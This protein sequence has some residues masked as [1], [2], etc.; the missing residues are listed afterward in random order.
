MT[1]LRNQ[2]LGRLEERDSNLFARK[3][4]SLGKIHKSA[5]LSGP[6]RKLE[7]YN[8]NGKGKKDKFYFSSLLENIK[9]S[10][11]VNTRKNK[12]YLI[13]ATFAGQG[14]PSEG[15]KPRSSRIVEEALIPKLSARMKLSGM[16]AFGIINE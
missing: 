5:F 6:S 13:S 15:V 14:L 4:S 16:S 3:D 10:D 1:I 8:R 11:E 9:K 7:D 12:N 2:S